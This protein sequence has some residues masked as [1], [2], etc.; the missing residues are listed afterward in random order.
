MPSKWAQGEQLKPD[1]LERCQQEQ[2]AACVS[3]LDLLI[4]GSYLFDAIPPVLPADGD[5]SNFFIFKRILKQV[6]KQNSK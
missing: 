1:M 4:V 3:L 5:Q 6:A 2:P